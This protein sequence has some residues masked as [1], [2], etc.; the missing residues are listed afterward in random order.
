MPS[1]G[2]S[3]PPWKS[4]GQQGEDSCRLEGEALCGRQHVSDLFNECE[5][6]VEALERPL[7]GQAKLREEPVTAGDES[8]EAVLAKLYFAEIQ[9]GL[10]V[11]PFQGQDTGEE[12]LRI[13]PIF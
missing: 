9:Q 5:Q 11:T 13:F 12:R 7:P 4:S 10:E 8:F 1:S 6:V 3:R 2:K